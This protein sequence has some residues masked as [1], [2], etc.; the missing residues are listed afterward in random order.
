MFNG[1]LILYLFNV[2]LFYELWRY[3]GAPERRAGSDALGYFGV[4]VASTGVFESS[5]STVG[6][7]A[8]NAP[9]ASILP[10]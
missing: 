10:P 9:L 6:T 8:C 3:F 5:A 4:A 1:R 7:I 2:H